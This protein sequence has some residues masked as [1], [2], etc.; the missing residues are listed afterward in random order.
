LSSV[1]GPELFASVD[2][3]NPD[4]L[5]DLSDLVNDMG[6]NSGLDASTL[7]DM[8][9]P[10][11]KRPFMIDIPGMFYEPMTKLHNIIVVPGSATDVSTLA[12][13]TICG[14]EV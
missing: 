14:T 9:E 4:V 13:F 3:D 2:T 5:G 6:D 1:L 8:K 10:V 12:Q 7:T 11:I